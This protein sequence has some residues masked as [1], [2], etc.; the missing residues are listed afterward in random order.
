MFNIPRFDGSRVT[1]TAKD[2]STAHHE[3]KSHPAVSSTAP[4]SE[5]ITSPKINDG[6]VTAGKT[7][8]RRTR[9]RRRQNEREQALK[10][11]QKEE[12]KT[13]ALEGK[14]DPTARP[15]GEVRIKERKKKRKNE[16]TIEDEGTQ[17]KKIKVTSSEN[18][19]NEEVDEDKNEEAGEKK[20]KKVS[21]ED[22][23]MEVDDDNKKEAIKKKKKKDNSM[24]VDD[25]NKNKE[26]GIKKKKKKD[27]AMEVDDDD[28]DKEEK[29]EKK[30]KKKRDTTLE[31][32]ETIEKK[33]DESVDEKKIEND[34]PVTAPP[35]D[36]EEM[37][38]LLASLSGVRALL[39]PAA[40]EPKKPKEKKL[41]VNWTERYAVIDPEK[42]DRVE[43]VPLLHPELCKA[44]QKEKFT[45]FFPVQSCVVPFLLN[46]VT[47]GWI[48][49]FSRY[50]C[51]VCVA[52]PTGQGKTLCYLLPILH[53]IW[54][55]HPQPQTRAIICV[56]TRDLAKQV[57]AVA[58]RF[59][60]YRSSGLN[61]CCIVG[62]S[63]YA[64]E[65]KQL[66][67]KPDVVICTPGRLVDHLMDEKRAL[68]LSMLRWFVADEADRLLS[69][70]YQRWLQALGILTSRGTATAPVDPLTASS[71]AWPLCAKAGQLPPVRKL[72][73]SA[74]MTKNPQKLAALRLERPFFFLASATGAHVS[75][76][77]LVHEYQ[78]VK[79]PKVQMLLHFLQSRSKVIV[80]CAAIETAH[81]LA[82]MLEIYYA[83]EEEAHTQSLKDVNDAEK[84]EDVNENKKD[85]FQK[86]IVAEF[87]SLLPQWERERLLKKFQKGE[88]NCLVCSDVA[89]RGIDLP[90]VEAVINYDVPGHLRTYVH[91]AGRTARAGSSGICRTILFRREMYHFKQMISK[92][93]FGWDRLQNVIHTSDDR[94]L[95]QKGRP[96]FRRAMRLLR[97]CATDEEN[98]IFDSRKPIHLSSLE[99]RCKNHFDDDERFDD[100]ED[101]EEGSDEE[102]DEEEVIEQEKKK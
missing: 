30:K 86:P 13:A 24:E 12:S 64:T 62:T 91:R 31:E 70:D 87:S 74:T 54:D 22:S 96:H 16:T 1:E 29:I 83:I 23:T 88:I 80:F 21:T 34:A 17:K 42:M 99:K 61:V 85:S 32:D 39:A 45:T 44:L 49:P 94:T 40:P 3:P 5:E 50:A 20:K 15:E 75:P 84:K 65:K 92:S 47:S 8:S 33:I 71:L 66:R 67:A 9:E 52:A 98:G 102:D 38:D 58:R 35:E 63:D 95:I 82:R 28:K 7:G 25:D 72:L 36:E 43:D 18:K 79:G 97:Q 89:A 53:A 73:F 78:V 93:E 2:T 11:K 56:P 6:L 4:V 55:L 19:E 26:D 90:Q 77:E 41:Q 81:R 100:E 48:D 101:D 57:A 59:A 76:I 46:M 14:P 68:N 60:P 10:K 69:Q 51:D 37:Q 27:D